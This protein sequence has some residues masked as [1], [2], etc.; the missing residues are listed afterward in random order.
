MGSDYRDVTLSEVIDVK[1]GFAYAGEDITD[2]VQRDILF[3][4]GNF[5]IGGGFKG[6][7]YKYFKGDTPDEY[8]L[9][10]GDLVVTM[11]DL[12]KQT[13]TLGFP[14]LVPKLKGHRFLHNQ[15]I[16]KVVIKNTAAIDKLYLF[17]SSIN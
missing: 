3:T 12:S 8:V 11:T 1:H 13:D 10:D 6:D 4:P 16:G 15:R 17:N 9:N 7:K 14:A 2:E 5:A